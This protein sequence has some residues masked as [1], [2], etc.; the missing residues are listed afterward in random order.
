MSKDRNFRGMLEERWRQGSVCVGLDSDLAKIP[1][2][3]QIVDTRHPSPFMG[4]D[5]EETLYEFTCEIFDAIKDL[6][7]TAKPNVAFFEAWGD[8]GWRALRRVYVHIREVAPEV[9]VIHDAKRGDIGNTNLGYIRSAFEYLG[10][11]AITVSPYLGQEALQPFLDE[12]N[13]G[14]IVLCKTSNKGAGEF[15]DLYVSVPL[16]EIK[17]MQQVKATEWSCG[18][19]GSYT[20]LSNHVAYR[21]SKYWNENGNCAVVV[22]ATYPSELENVRKI[23]GD[24]PILIPA[25]GFQQK[26]IPLEKQVEQVVQAGQDSRGKG[27]II[28][29]SRGI[30]FANSGQKYAEAAR[31]ETLKLHNIVNKYRKKAN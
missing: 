26:D 9:P 1:E 16:D 15:Q 2:S 17:H 8:A 21:V 4:L 23:I 30:I 20:T 24:M 29:S 3:A 25:V 14:I 10:A 19:P 27:M 6:V 18:L 31:A 13:K 11:D 12:V 7:S 28:N 5:S 22:G